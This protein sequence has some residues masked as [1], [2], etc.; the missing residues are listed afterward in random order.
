[1]STST[2][3][4]D[5][6]PRR[7]RDHHARAARRRA[8]TWVQAVLLLLVMLLINMPLILTAVNSFRPRLDIMAG[9]TL[10]PERVTLEN[11]QAVFGTTRYTEWFLNSVWVSLVATVVVLIASG[12]AGYSLSRYR[13]RVNS[14]YS[15]MLMV[16]QLFPLVLSIV[17]LMVLFVS[18]GLTKTFV[19]A[20]VLYIVMAL[21]FC[22]W[23][24]KGF[25]DSIPRELEE[26]ARVDGCSSFRAMISVVIP[27]AGP[28]AAAVAIY[29]FLLA[30]NEYMVAS[31][32]LKNPSS[33]NTISIG[34]RSFFQQNTTEWGQMLAASTL[35]VLPPLVLFL[36]VQKWMIRGM[37]AGAVKG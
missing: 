10:V 7:V 31:A 25:F 2:T 16:F 15:N 19:P 28:G 23:M 17:G 26:A 12:F 21:P 13:T 36:L 6:T 24:F 3:S 5:T 18:V 9:S 8:F 37:A 27:L 20:I 33:L 1:M 34:L 14:V 30:Y 22:T 4:A 11:Y 35:A 32:F 29:A